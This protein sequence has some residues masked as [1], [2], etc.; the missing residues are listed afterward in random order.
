[1]VVG[2]ENIYIYKSSEYEIFFDS[3]NCLVM[4]CN[5]LIDDVLTYFL[6]GTSIGCF[7]DC[8]FGMDRLRHLIFGWRLLL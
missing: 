7:A 5:W 2:P 1:M 8:L 3:L 6:L 4:D